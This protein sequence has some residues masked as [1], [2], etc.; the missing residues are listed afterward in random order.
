MDENTKPQCFGQKLGHEF[1]T[2]GSNCARCGIDPDKLSGGLTKIEYFVRKPEKGMHSEMHALAKEVSE[3]CGEPKK[4]GMYL[5]IIKN[6]GLPKAYRI[7]SE[8]RQGKEIKTP[9]RK[10]DE[11]GLVRGAGAAVPTQPRG[12]VINTERYGHDQPLKSA[13][14]P[15]DA[16]R[17]NPFAGAG[18]A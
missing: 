12:D 9:G 18:S 1:L 13:K 16:L 17:V 5:G 3:Y 11:D 4:F 7:F 2:P 10:I 15:L 8:I 6:I 14:S